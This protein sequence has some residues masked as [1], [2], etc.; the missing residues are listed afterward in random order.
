MASNRV[1]SSSAAVKLCLDHKAII[2]A[3]T[4]CFCRKFCITALFLVIYIMA[5]GLNPLDSV[6]LVP[7]HNLTILPAF[8]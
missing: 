6:A 7:A 3:Q 2:E 8:N 1:A 4:A 5:T